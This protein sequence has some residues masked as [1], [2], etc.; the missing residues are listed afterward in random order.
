VD[1]CC[2]CTVHAVYRRCCTAHTVYRICCTASIG[3]RMCCTAHTSQKI[4]TRRVCLLGMADRPTQHTVKNMHNYI[5]AHADTY[6]RG[7]T[8]TNTQTYI[9]SCTYTDTLI[10]KRL[11]VH[12]YVHTQKDIHI[13]TELHIKDTYVYTHIIINTK[14][15]YKLTV[16][17]QQKFENLQTE[18][19]VKDKFS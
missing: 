4:N 19:C 12:S 10:R 16:H 17:L 7:Y 8:Y 14:I 11:Q 5:R 2:F 15:L 3:Y 9:H 1:F 13:R 6:V 18:S